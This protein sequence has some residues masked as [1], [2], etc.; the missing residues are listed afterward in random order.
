MD[1]VR[2]FLGSRRTGH[3]ACSSLTKVEVPFPLFLGPPAQHARKGPPSW[4]QHSESSKLGS[5]RLPGV[6]GLSSSSFLLVRR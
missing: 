2:L 4:G 1:T 5:C 3:D 6:G